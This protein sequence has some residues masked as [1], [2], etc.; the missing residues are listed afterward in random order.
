MDKYKAKQ[1][2]A[3]L[4]SKDFL[5]YKIESLLD[6]G[7]SAAVFKASDKDGN[8]VAIK[9]FDSD[10]IERFGYEIQEQR[11]HQEISLKGHKIPNLIEILDGGKTQIE[12]NE[13]Y[14]IIMK[15]ID[16]VNFKQY[17]GANEYDNKFLKN[18]V[19]ILFKVTEAL[20][21][22][23]IVHRDIKPENIMIDK[24]GQ[25]FLMDLGVLK[26]IGADSLSDEE[27]K[28]FVGTL[29]YA[30]PEFLR[31]IEEDSAEG[32]RAVNLYQIGA[33]LHDLIMKKELFNEITPYSNL[34]ISIKED[35]PQITSS[36]Y[37]FQTVQITRDLLLKDW[38]KRVQL[39]SQ[40]RIV[41]FYSKDDE[42]KTSIEK[43]LEEIFSVTSEH[44]TKADEIE[45]LT[46]SNQEKDLKRKEISEKLETVVSKCI[47]GLREKGVF[48]KMEKSRSFQFD[49]DRTSTPKNQI[50]K[51]ILYKIEGDISKGFLKPLFFL[52]R[53]V[54]DEN[55]LAEIAFLAIFLSPFI[56]INMHEPTIM[57]REIMNEQNPVRVRSA[58]QQNQSTKIDLY[59]AFEG[60]IG[61]DEQFEQSLMLEILKLIRTALKDVAPHVKL[62]LER[63][64]QYARGEN[65]TYHTPRIDK[66]KLYH[67]IV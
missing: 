64:E 53:T 48:D 39:C 20:I 67:K 30:P 32:W 55:S 3:Y 40:N 26:L 58:Y 46:R 49:S 31:R 38:R 25:I 1:L 21:G 57:F 18:V 45:K 12:A 28:Q 52:V 34:V 27:E 50:I 13:Y 24:E 62:E 51:N 17:I 66:T 36:I 10:L 42:N 4:L 7:K 44:K 35:A 9:I 6:N 41:E 54:N 63:R 15:Y 8:F 16:G 19:E 47:S 11:I 37:P 5:N 43:E 29:R 33:V 65:P 2:E 59:Q 56:K 61:F 14:Y 22:I 23:N 60:T